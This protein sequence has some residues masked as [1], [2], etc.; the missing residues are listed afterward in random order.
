MLRDIFLQENYRV[1]R[2]FIDGLLSRSKP[3]K[4]VLKEYGN[5]IHTLL[6]DSKLRVHNL[7]YG[8]YYYYGHDDDD[9]YGLYDSSW[10]DSLLL[11]HRTACEGN[12]NII[13]F[14]LDSVQ[15]AENRQSIHAVASTRQKQTYSLAPCST[16]T[17]HAGIREVM[18]VC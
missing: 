4:Q 5:Q 7:G 18:G 6:K 12:A 1:V 15:A 2:V 13:G 9:D 14:L 17:Q 11:L 16:F 8:D 3:S 10:G